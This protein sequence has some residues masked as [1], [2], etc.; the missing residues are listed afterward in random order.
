[1]GSAANPVN[2]TRRELRKPYQP[3]RLLRLVDVAD[4]RIHLDIRAAALGN[5]FTIGLFAAS[6]NSSSHSPSE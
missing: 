3:K 6:S 1:M 2:S 4:L 5:T